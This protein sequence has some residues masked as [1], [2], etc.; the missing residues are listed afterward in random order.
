[1]AGKPKTEE[2]NNSTFAALKETV[3]SIAPVIDDRT[4]LRID[5]QTANNTDWEGKVY[6]YAGVYVGGKWYMTG[7]G[8]L[9]QAE[10]ATTVAL[11]TALASYP[12][13]RS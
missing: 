13:S 6:T 10:Y 7:Y 9:L 3:D 12:G 5:V 1:M 2:V 11:I 4:M 8:R